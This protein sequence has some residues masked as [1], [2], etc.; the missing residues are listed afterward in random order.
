MEHFAHWLSASDIVLKALM[1]LRPLQGEM[2]G[3]T[4]RPGQHQTAN[5]YRGYQGGATKRR[6]RWGAV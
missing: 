5:A 1:V 4:R 6:E 3:L 2:E